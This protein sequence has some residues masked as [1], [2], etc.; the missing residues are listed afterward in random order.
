MGTTKFKKNNNMH[1]SKRILKTM[2]DF[3]LICDQSDSVMT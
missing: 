1:Q 3:N 2:K